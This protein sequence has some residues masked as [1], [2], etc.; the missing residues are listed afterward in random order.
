MG[1]YGFCGDGAKELGQGDMRA[2]RRR[3][4][5]RRDDGVQRRVRLAPLETWRRAGEQ[6]SELTFLGERVR[7]A[8]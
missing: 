3:N 5:G 4:D 1:Q 2:L 8:Q 6:T 7:D